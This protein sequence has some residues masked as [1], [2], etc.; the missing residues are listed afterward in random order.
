MDHN[1]PDYR[2][3]IASDNW[4][5]TVL[6]LNRSARTNATARTILVASGS[7]NA[8]LEEIYKWCAYVKGNL[9]D[10]S[11]ADLYLFLVYNEPI[12]DLEV[13]LKVE[14]NELYCRKYVL[15]PRERFDELLNRTFLSEPTAAAAGQERSEPLIQALQETATNFPWLT[16]S[17]L[18]R[19][20]QV[21]LAEGSGN[22][23]ATSLYQE[24][25][26]NE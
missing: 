10:P 4:Q 22:Q 21:L 17:E 2:W 11:T 18:E 26:N 25:S 14:A 8:E 13:C 24:P 3:P 7:N 1:S 23:L 12:P 6:T 9:L 16:A 5:K 19:W 20:R 15:R